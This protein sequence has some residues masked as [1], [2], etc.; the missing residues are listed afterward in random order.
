MKNS[1]NSIKEKILAVKRKAGSVDENSIKPDSLVVKGNNKSKVSIPDK[2]VAVKKKVSSVEEN[3]IEPEPQVIRDNNIPSN[4]PCLDYRENEAEFFRIA[5]EALKFNFSKLENSTSEDMLYEYKRFMILKALFKD[6]S[7]SYLS[8]SASVDEV[9]HKMLLFPAEYYR[10]CNVLLH[11]KCEERIIDHNPEGALEDAPRLE[12]YKR[13][14]DAYR[15]F[16]KEDPPDEFWPKLKEQSLK[17][18]K[19]TFTTSKSSPDSVADRESEPLTIRLRDHTGDEI[20]VSYK[21]YIHL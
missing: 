18:T 1:K 11:E 10:L 9:W 12:R 15:M 16:F 19:S 6:T 2:I 5:S 21:F 17:K 7:C 8:P 4:R 20:F 13:T 14:L 3:S